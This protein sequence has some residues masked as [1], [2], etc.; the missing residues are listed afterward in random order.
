ME[1]IEEGKASTSKISSPNLK[2]KKVF[3]LVGKEA[4][5]QMDDDGFIHQWTVLYEKCPWATVFQSREYVVSWYL[6]FKDEYEPLIVI[7]SDHEGNL[8][9]LLTMTIPKDNIDNSKKI[10]IQGAGLY[11]AEYQ[12]WL[13]EKDQNEMFIKRAFDLILNQFPKADI[14]FRYVPDKGLIAG[15]EKSSKWKYKRVIQPFRR[16]LMNTKSPQI[17]NVITPKSQYKAKLKK[18]KRLKG[19]NFRRITEKHEFEEIFPQII[20]QFDFRQ[21]AMFNKSQFRESPQKMDFYLKLFEKGL[22]HVT[23]LSIKGEVLGSMVAL[24]GKNWV[25]LQ[26]INTYS[27]IYA[28]YSPGIILFYL[29]GELLVSDGVDVFDLTPGW[30]KY[31]ENW[32]TE[33]DAVYSFVLTKDPVFY[34]KRKFR[35][36]IYG[37]LL[38]MRFRPMSVELFWSKQWYMVKNKGIWSY[39]FGR[40]NMGLSKKNVSFYFF[41]GESIVGREVSIRK[42]SIKDLLKY[43]HVKPGLTR[44][45]FMEN[46]M[47]SLSGQN[48]IYTH[49]KGDCLLACAKV[50]RGKNGIV[51]EKSL[52]KDVRFM[53]LIYSHV[54][55]EDQVSDFILSVVNAV[56]DP[57]EDIRVCLIIEDR[58]KALNQVIQNSEFRPALV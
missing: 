18:L 55:Y 46:A 16:P 8:T 30:D 12:V 35:V 43:K 2:Q 26:G 56:L 22:L 37:V 19:Y 6:A 50:Y 3:L 45:E 57:N 36:F 32:K 14:L 49:A 17:F 47:Y 58:N 28:K 33:S 41:K 34:L 10:K 53:E 11:E 25:H 23:V 1:L 24:R 51:K 13:V 20:D 38:K 48:T 44:W 4:F 40:G 29:L 15:F 52:G 39:V 31:K 9:G 54:E 21:A 27:P 7:S 5:E 42:N